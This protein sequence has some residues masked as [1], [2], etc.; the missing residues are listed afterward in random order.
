MYKTKFFLVGVIAALTL[1]LSSCSH[2]VYP[3]D[4]LEYN[5]HMRMTSEDEL[6]AKAKVKIFLSENDV[7]DN[8]TVI[9]YNSYSP[10]RFP[11][12]V[13]YKKQMGK[14]FFQKAVMK[15]Y[16]EGGNGIIV[17]AGGY[18]KVIK[19][20]N[21]DSDKELPAAFVNVIFNRS[22]M[23]KFVNGEIGQMSKSDI[24][25]YESMLTDEIFLNIGSAKTMDEISFIKEKISV[26]R[27]YNVSL[28]K[29]K[30]KIYK[31]LE[32]M[33]K[34]IKRVEKRVKKRMAKENK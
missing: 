4:M 16:E 26:L 21:W 2:T 28:A 30:Q 6:Q 5:Y 18:Y 33:D 23:D 31:D 34:R 29:P 17:T 15:A 19:I 1:S 10:V 22:T 24:K 27:S 7:K 3:T 13:N 25:R 9:S 8:Y 11:I 12:F 32:K 20:E 14:K